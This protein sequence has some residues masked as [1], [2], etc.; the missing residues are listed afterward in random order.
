M[1]SWIAVICICVLF[2]LP[3]IAV[4]LADT[5]LGRKAGIHLNPNGKE[6]K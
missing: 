4:I 2:S 3:T 6:R 1:S 5:E